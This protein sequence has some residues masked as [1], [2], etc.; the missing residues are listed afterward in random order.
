LTRFIL[1]D[2]FR[3]LQFIVPFLMIRYISWTEV[4]RE[5]IQAVSSHGFCFLTLVMLLNLS[6]EM[7]VPVEL[8]CLLAHFSCAL[9]G[10]S[11][12]GSMNTAMSETPTH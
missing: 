7:A 9:L 4:V 6:A 10:L 5:A 3:P 12:T 8:E 1:E 11:E 2:F